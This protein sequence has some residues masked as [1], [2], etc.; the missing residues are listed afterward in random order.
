MCIQCKSVIASMAGV[1]SESID[2]RLSSLL[3]L[4]VEVCYALVVYLGI[5]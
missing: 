1:S 2:A 3:S 5:V 4:K